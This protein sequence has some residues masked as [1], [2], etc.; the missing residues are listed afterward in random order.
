VEKVLLIVR[1]FEA[2]QQRDVFFAEALTSMMMFLILNL[3]G[4]HD[5]PLRSLPAI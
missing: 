3:G 1:H 5:M 4:I 2:F